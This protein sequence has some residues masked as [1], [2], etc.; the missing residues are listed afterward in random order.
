LDREFSSLFLSTVQRD[1]ED[2][3]EIQTETTVTDVD[4]HGRTV[5]APNKHDGFDKLVLCTGFHWEQLTV[6]GA[7]LKG[8]HSSRTSGAL[9]RRGLEVKFI[10]EGP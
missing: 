1:V 3:L 9:A 4:L 6:P 10:D 2:G 8:I 5:T 7:N